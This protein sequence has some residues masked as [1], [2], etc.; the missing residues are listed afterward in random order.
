MIVGSPGMEVEGTRRDAY[1]VVLFADDGSRK[2]YRSYAA[3]P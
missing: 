3:Q 1:D 2:V